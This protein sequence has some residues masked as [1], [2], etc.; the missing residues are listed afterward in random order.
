[1]TRLPMAVTVQHG[2]WISLLASS[3]ADGDYNGNGTLDAGDLDLHAS[4]GIANQDLKYDANG[5][6]TVDVE[7]RVVWTNDLKNTWMGDSDLNGVFDSSDFVLVF[8]E[9]RYETGES[10]TWGQG[11]WDGDQKFDSGD[12]VAAFANGGYEMGEMPGGPNPVTAV[13][14][15]PSSMVL[16]LISLLGLAGVARRRNG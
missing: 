10:A 16:A 11:D 7:D 3:A 15:E 5:D 2:T 8:G 13:V 12:F 6:G 1:M 9:G 4:E 14:P